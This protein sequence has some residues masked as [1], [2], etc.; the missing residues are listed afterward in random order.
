VIATTPLL[1]VHSKA[2]AYAVPL[3]NNTS[4]TIGRSQSN[5]IVLYDR[6]AS[7]QH[8][9]L[10]L[11]NEVE[12]YL[13]DLQSRNGTWLRGK[14]ITEP[15]CLHHETQFR[16]GEHQ[17][18][19]RLGSAPFQGTCPSGVS[20]RAVFLA[21]PTGWQEQ[22]WRELLMSQGIFVLSEQPEHTQ[23]LLTE[24]NPAL[25]EL[26]ILFGA[27]GEMAALVENYRQ[28]FP[29][30][31]ILLVNTSAAVIAQA[32][33]DWA[34]AQGLLDILARLPEDEFVAK[35]V[36]F[37]HALKKVLHYLDWRPIQEKELDS[38]LLH[39]QA[40]VNNEDLSQSLEDFV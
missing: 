30:L 23:A 39:L 1:I 21:A 6:W 10:E 8:A 33:R 35:A 32:E 11:R 2:T 24:M 13:V 38:A 17:L 20:Q 5:A 9:R 14:R 12:I 28:R 31:P 40:Q 3:T 29:K 4:W 26:L 25:P 16:I 37:G 7:R 22:I 19:F 36:S 34:K 15:I 27:P 18:E